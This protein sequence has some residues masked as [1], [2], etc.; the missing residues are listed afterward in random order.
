MDADMIQKKVLITDDLHPL[1]IEGLTK[2]GYHIDYQPDITLEAV[3]EVIHEYEGLIINSKILVDRRLLDKAVRL[4]FVARLGSGMEIV[5]KPYAAQKGVAVLSSPEGNCN[6]VAEHALGMLLAFANNLLPADREVRQKI[7]LREKNRGFELAEKTIGII[8]FGHTGSALAQKLQGMGMRVL[9]YDKYKTD[10]TQNFEYVEE[11]TLEA[12]QTH[13]DIISFHLPLNP[14]TKYFFDTNFLKK[15]SKKILLLN[16][17]RGNVVKTMDLIEA[18]NNKTILGACIDVFENEKPTT[19][20]QEE[21]TMYEQLYTFPNVILSPHVAGWTH[22]SKYKL[23][24][25]LL[26]KIMEI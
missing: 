23:S 2:L 1:M 3:R 25:V 8:G 5:D 26:E 11:T 6:A 10:Y 4:R 9:A 12:I 13:A 21:A 20:T 16:T 17:S 19:F 22:E 18:L 24:K 7:W 15:C 14:E